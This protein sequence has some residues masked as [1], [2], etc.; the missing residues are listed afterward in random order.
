MAILGSS[1][2]ELPGTNLIPMVGKQKQC[3]GS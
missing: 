1:E 3:R 2:N